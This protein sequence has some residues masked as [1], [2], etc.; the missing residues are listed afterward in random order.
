[1][2]Y[3]DF[4]RLFS[5]LL[6][7]ALAAVALP[8]G[9]AAAQA[10]IPVILD[11]DIGSDI[12]DTWALA[13][14]LKSPEL[15]LKLVVTETGDTTYRAKL[16]AKL[17]EAAKRSDIPVGI[18]LPTRQG[19]SRQADWVKDY[20]LT[21]YRGKVHKD[22][23]QA[24]IDTIMKSTQ[25]VTLICIGPVPNIR[26][27]LKREPRIAEKARFVGM[28]GSVHKQ[29]D[30]K[31]GVTP[32]YNVKLDPKACQAAFTAPWDMTI[33]PLDTCGVV[34]LEGP[35]YDKVRQCSDPLIQAM[36]ENYRVWLKGDANR[37]QKGSSI[38]FDTVAVYLAFSHD[39][40]TMEELGIRVTDDGKTVIDPSAKKVKCATEWKDLKGF[41][42]LLTRRLTQ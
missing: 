21:A 42:E 24:L 33:T 25:T 6:I 5:S 28:H 36:I 31:P 10:P 18:G 37:L 41:Y 20:D 15:D 17:L 39:L 22:G 7:P 13:F 19:D 27:A 9:V 4:P 2:H 26:E 32:E 16:V 8:G 30:G 38:L 1:M 34:R 12:D 29:Y 40:L 35:L 23:V 11:T 14:L 3:H